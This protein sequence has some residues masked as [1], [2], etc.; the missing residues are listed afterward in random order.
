MIVWAP[1]FNRTAFGMMT[2]S[3]WAN[4][5]SRELGSRDVVIAILG[6]NIP[7]FLYSSSIVSTGFSCFS[8]SNS[9]S[10]RKF[11]STFLNSVGMDR[12]PIESEN[13]KNWAYD[14]S[15]ETE[16][17]YSVSLLS[18]SVYAR[19]VLSLCPLNP[20][21]INIRDEDGHYGVQTW[22]RACQSNNV[23]T[24]H[25]IR[26]IAVLTDN[27]PTETSTEL[28]HWRKTWQLF[29]LYCI[30]FPTA[31]CSHCRVMT[32]L[33][34]LTY[35]VCWRIASQ[36]GWSPKWAERSRID[37]CDFIH[38][39]T[40]FWDVKKLKMRTWSFHVTCLPTV[41]ARQSDVQTSRS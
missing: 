18:V 25:I 28:C 10:C 5:L 14:E 37:S 29:P 39:H 41:P 35:R 20:C 7:A 8:S 16:V 32:I 15:K 27:N 1:R 21:D 22:Q 36:W 24:F 30:V 33:F 13:Q 3:S 4:C 17:V 34:F 2:R 9:I 6:S 38:M 40:F 26:Y 23:I 12:P 19:K 11:C 31:L